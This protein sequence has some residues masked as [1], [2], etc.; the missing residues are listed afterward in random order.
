MGCEFW[1]S[2]WKWALIGFVSGFFAAI[3]VI[4]LSSIK[5]QKTHDEIW[6]DRWKN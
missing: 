1:V 6:D 5:W 4:G 3:I 2:G